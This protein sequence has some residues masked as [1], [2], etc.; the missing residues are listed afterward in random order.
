LLVIPV[1]RMRREAK[2]EL[3]EKLSMVPYL[4]RSIYLLANGP[5]IL[6]PTLDL[7]LSINLDRR[8]LSRVGKNGLLRMAMSKFKRNLLVVSKAIYPCL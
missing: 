5:R 1:L 4:L 7:I 6:H 3:V 8:Y 2:A